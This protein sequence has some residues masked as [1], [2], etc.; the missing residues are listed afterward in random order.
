MLDNSCIRSL[1]VRVIDNCNA[2]MILLVKY[3]C[4][5]LKA[6]VLKLAKFIS[7]VLI[8]STR[9]HYQVCK[10]VIIFLISK[11]IF[12]KLHVTIS[13]QPVRK[14]IVTA[15][16]NTLVSVIKVVVIICVSY[17]KPLNDKCRK[18]LTV[19]S[20]LLLCI[21]LYKLLVDIFSHKAYCLLLEILRLAC[22]G[23]LLLIYLSLSLCRSS[24]SP[25]L[26]ECVHIERHVIHLAFIIGNRAVRIPVKFN[27]RIYK[28]PYFLIACMENVCA[29]LMYMYALH[30][31]TVDIAAKV[32]PLLNYKA[33]FPCL[34]C[35]ICDNPVV[36]SASHK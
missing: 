36:K 11:I 1:S 21:T 6:S 29:V 20:P 18:L 15:Y 32:L 35:I 2:L 17:R 30:I 14:L 34:C 13:I 24:Y 5:K 12:A 9:I 19:S 22:Y 23:A 28:I 25:H 26:I 33:L 3:L 27:E 4:F 8:N 31:L 7:V 16:R 10:S